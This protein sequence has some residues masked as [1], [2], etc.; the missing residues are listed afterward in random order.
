[1]NFHFWAQSGSEGNLGNWIWVWSSS[2]CVGQHREPGLALV[3]YFLFSKLLNGIMVEFLL[4]S[5]ASSSHRPEAAP[6]VT[7]LLSA[8]EDFS[9]HILF[10]FSLSPCLKSFFWTRALPQEVC[11]TAAGSVPWGHLGMA[12]EGSG[13]LKKTPFLEVFA[14]KS[15]VHM[16]TGLFFVA[17]THLLWAPCLS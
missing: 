15:H 5:K 13:T 10:H 12:P 11:D 3:F 8:Q 1:M 4:F 7:E 14:V 9:S 17:S 16:A 2:F 6:C